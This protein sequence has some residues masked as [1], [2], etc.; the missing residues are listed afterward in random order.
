M[1]RFG[2]SAIRS[3]EQ[4]LS[5]DHLYSLLAP[6]AFARAAVTR[7]NLLPGYFDKK[8]S[9]R[10]LRRARMNYLLSR[11]VSFFPDRLASGKWQARFK[12]NGLERIQ[13]AREQKRR[14]VLVVFHFGTLK[15][16]P[17]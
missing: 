2:F 13:E 14:V 4:R 5:L 6:F 10:T 9:A 17:F 16:I 3:L 1:G 15:L 7:H 11:M 12:T 8:T